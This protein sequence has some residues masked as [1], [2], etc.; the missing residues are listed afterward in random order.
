MGHDPALV[1]RLIPAAGDLNQ[2]HGRGI[3]L[4]QFAVLQ[5]KDTERIDRLAA[6]SAGP[7]A[8]I[9]GATLYSDTLLSATAIGPRLTQFPAGGGS[10]SQCTRPRNIAQSGGGPFDRGEDDTATELLRMMLD[11]GADFQFAGARRLRA[12]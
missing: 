6:G 9:P 11:H 5:A 2:P 1:K 12:G 7:P 10:E 4:W 3:T 8:T